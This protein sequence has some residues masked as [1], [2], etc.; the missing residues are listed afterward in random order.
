VIASWELVSDR[1]GHTISQNHRGVVSEH[2][3]SDRRFDA[4]TRRAASYDQVLHA[5]LL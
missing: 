2:C 1:F 5:Q 4:H 3:I